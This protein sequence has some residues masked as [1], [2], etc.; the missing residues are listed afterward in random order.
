[1][2]NTLVVVGSGIKS[3]SHLSIEA[4]AHIS[5]SEKILYSVN[6]PILKQWI[7]KHNSNAE[8]LDKEMTD[9]L[10][11][12]YY[13]NIT[14]YILKN[15]QQYSQICVLLYGHPTVFAIPALNAAREAKKLGFIVKVLPAISA[16]DCLFA[17][18]LI[19]PGSCGCQSYEATD[20]LIHSR[21]V[22]IYSHLVLWQVGFIGALSNIYSHNN[23]LGIKNLSEYL[24]QFYK[25]NHQVI[26]YE[27]AMYPHLESKILNFSLDKLVDIPFSTLSTL[28]VPPVAHASLNMSMLNE[29]NIKEEHLFYDIS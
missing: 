8:S 6:E 16:E 19:D 12:I 26:S 9:D 14:D 15:F 20:F 24:L 5:Q 1:M 22:N 18:L 4:I 23:R 17:D 2:R 27:A 25:K 13:K 7:H 21:P 11:S 28:Y 3:I 10:R 29:L